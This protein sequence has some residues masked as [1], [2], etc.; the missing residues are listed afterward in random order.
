MATAIPFGDVPQVYNNGSALSGG[1]IYF[2]VPGT[3]TLR[4]PYSDTAL[5]VPTTN[6]VLLNSAGW[7]ATNIYLD[8]SL[9]YDYIIKSADDASTL[10][11]R[12]TIPAA[13]AELYDATTAAIAALTFADG[14]MLEATGDDTFTTVKPRFGTYDEMRAYTASEAAVVQKIDVTGYGGGTFVW[15]G[16]GHADYDVSVIDEDEMTTG[17]GDGRIFATPTADKTG[18]SGYWKRDAY[19]PGLPIHLSWWQ[20]DPTEGNDVGPMLYKAIMACERLVVYDGAS[21]DFSAGLVLIGPGY[22][23][24]DTLCDAVTSKDLQI[25]IRGAGQWATLLISSATN[26]DGI[27]RIDGRNP[28]VRASRET[29]RDIGFRARANATEFALSIPDIEGGTNKGYGLI[30]KQLH[31]EGMESAT[32]YFK[33]AYYIPGNNRI[34]ME[35]VTSQGVQSG[36]T[37]DDSDASSY[38]LMDYGVVVDGAY[39]VKMKDCHFDRCKWPIRNHAGRSELSGVRVGFG[40]IISV[41]DDGSG[42][43]KFTLDVSTHGISVS[44]QVRISAA[45]VYQ[46]NTATVTA[47]SGADVTTDIAY[48]AYTPIR[49][50]RAWMGVVDPGG[51]GF[52]LYNCSGA[53]IMYGPDIR[54]VGSEAAGYVEK[55]CHWNSRYGANI[56]GAKQVEI[57]FPKSYNG[58]YN[59]SED[60]S[61]RW[62]GYQLRNVSEVQVIGGYS[63]FT[64]NPNSTAVKV[65]PGVVT[66]ER[67]TFDNFL[68]YDG[69]DIFIDL[70]DVTADE[71]DINVQQTSALESGNE[72]VVIG[73]NVTNARVRYSPLPSGVLITDNTTAGSTLMRSDGLYG[74]PDQLITL[75]ADGALVLPKNFGHFIRVTGSYNINAGFTLPAG[76][77][78]YNG[79]QLHI[80]KWAAGTT[81]FTTY[82]GGTDQNIDVGTTPVGLTATDMISFVFRS[83]SG[84]SAI[85]DRDNT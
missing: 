76:F 85:S 69:H 60:A 23:K 31:A 77:V 27:L 14:D 26:T 33:T 24:F 53:R 11:P 64:L 75:T 19:A 52:Q 13:S 17:E 2:Y 1:K 78:P 8:S 71:V 30:L 56:D 36:G 39:G 49:T 41:A 48:S 18:A 4:T 40:E 58:R 12:T 81:T 84:W 28:G 7:P 34:L 20:P 55:E 44:D 74:V 32:G 5:T 68:P 79:Y 82:S 61:F 57:K 22:F 16:T 37:V 29:V 54:L 50:D 42:F 10:W 38:F 70:N 21:Y 6:P 45:S 62:V 66:C 83:G 35:G 46:T 59:A 73:S 9:A 65:V 43:A 15:I 47:V 63:R 51:E 25:E 72:L 80:M 3:S 67:L